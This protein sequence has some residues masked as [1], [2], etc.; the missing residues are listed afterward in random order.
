LAAARDAPGDL[1]DLIA[2]GRIVS[3]YGIKGWV[4]ILPYTEEIDGLLQYGPP[5]WLDAAEAPGGSRTEIGIDESRVHGKVL[6]AHLKG[7]DDREQARA[8]CHREVLVRRDRLPVLED[9]AYYWHQLTGLKVYSSSCQP[10]ALLGRVERM[11]ETGANDVMVVVP[12]EGSVD[13]RERLLPFLPRQY[14]T[15]VDLAKGCLSMAWDPEF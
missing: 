8:H 13:G 2:V 4:K 6:A 14:A 10:P 12:C 15:Q 7:V 9:G 3:P 1:G 11:L 5:Y